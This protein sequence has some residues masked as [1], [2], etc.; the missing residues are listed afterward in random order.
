MHSPAVLDLL[1]RV[2]QRA[3]S[4]APSSSVVHSEPPSGPPSRGRE[5]RLCLK[6]D[7]P[8]KTPMGAGAGSEVGVTGKL[9]AT[10]ILPL[11]FGVDGSSSLRII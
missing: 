2:L 5:R 10:G 11:S 7:Q 3:A 4:L 6:L 8:V 9:K 1:E